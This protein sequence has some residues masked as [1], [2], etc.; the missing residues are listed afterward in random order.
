MTQ[1]YQTKAGRFAGLEALTPD[2][3]LLNMDALMLKAYMFQRREISAAGMVRMGFKD[4]DKLELE[5]QNMLK[6]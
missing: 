4:A 6:D 1:D 3:A 2:E 5:Y